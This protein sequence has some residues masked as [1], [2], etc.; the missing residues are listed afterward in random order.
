MT[1]S[2]LILTDNPKRSGALAYSVGSMA[3]TELMEIAQWPGPDNGEALTVVD[4]D[5]HNAETVARLKLHKAASTSPL[6]FVSGKDPRH[7][8]VQANVLGAAHVIPRTGLVKRLPGLIDLYGRR[9]GGWHS[10]SLAHELNL[11]LFGAVGRG[12]PLPHDRV[13]E[14]SDVIANSLSRD[15]IATWLS[16]VKHHHSYTHRHSLEVTGFAVAFGLCTGMREQDVHRLAA[17][18][19][20]HDVGKAKVPLSVLD[21]PGNLSRTERETMRRHPEF[22]GDILARDAQ[23]GEEIV[24]AALHH[25]EFLDGSGYPHGLMDSAIADFVRI[26]TI[27]DVFSALIDK[28]SYKKAIPADRAYEMMCATRGKFDEDFLLAFEPVAREAR[29]LAHAVSAEAV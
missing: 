2:I 5:L 25:H 20:L 7:D 24:D 12:E 28:R 23:F 17:G 8:A 26:V 27:A 21:K 16:E 10:V 22:S 29:T 9:T 15:G 14:C 13:M 19:L 4:V 18:A 1:R 3:R 6:V 11:D